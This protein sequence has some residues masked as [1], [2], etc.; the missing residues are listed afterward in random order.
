MSLFSLGWSD[1]WQTC[2]P[3]VSEAVPARILA[4]YGE[5]YLASYDGGE[6]EA[7]LTG[8]LRYT[9][10]S[11]AALPTVGDW[12][13]LRNEVIDEVLPRRT[14]VRR[15]APGRR[16]EEQALAANVD[17]V[18]IVSGLDRDLNPRR[19]ERYLVLAQDSGAQ[20]VLVLN[21]ADLHASPDEIR[22]TLGAVAGDCP[23][24]LT[25][26]VRGDGVAEVHAWLKEGFTGVL[27]GSS[28]AGK[29]TLIN[30]LLGETY[31]ATRAVRLG[32]DRGRHTTTHRQ[33][34]RLAEGG[35]LIDTPGLREIQLWTDE[36]SVAHVFGD[37]V[38]RARKCR[39]RDCHH[40]GEPGCAVLAAIESGELS[41]GR[42]SSFQK[43]QRELEH[44][45]CEEDVL[46]QQ[47]QKRLVKTIHREMRRRYQARAREDG[48]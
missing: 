29:S 7:E 21:K 4:V 23:V 3:A 34:F 14:L 2:V 32:D 30:A 42:F 16:Q 36:E 10:P 27:V 26:A 39:F 19:L 31:Q 24:V 22:A 35:M 43:L 9:A 5:R 44:I 33:L 1:F 41:A 37:V 47:R 20:P 46:L 45:R 17:L 48:A 12:V 15:R 40:Q 6:C 38:E 25:S 13:L 8:R 18:F 28:G 11:A